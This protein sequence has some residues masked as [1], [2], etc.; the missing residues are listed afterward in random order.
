MFVSDS[1]LFLEFQTRNR[2]TD[3][4]NRLADTAG[5]GEGGMNRESVTDTCTLLRVKQTASRKLLYT[6]RVQPGAL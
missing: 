6:Q 5:E 2:H 4:E 3:V 1:D